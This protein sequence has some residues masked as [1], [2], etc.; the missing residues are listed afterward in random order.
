MVM[1]PRAGCWC[2]HSYNKVNGV[3]R[4]SQAPSSSLILSC[5]KWAKLASWLQVPSCANKELLTGL[6]REQWKF[7]GYVSAGHLPVASAAQFRSDPSS[8]PLSGLPVSRHECRTPPLVWWRQVVSDC[9]AIQQVH[10]T[11]HY[12]NSL[13][14]AAS[15]A[16]RAG[17]DL[18][19][20]GGR[21]HLGIG[22]C[23]LRFTYVTPVLITKLRMET[24]GQVWRLHAPSHDSGG[25]R[26]GLGGSGGR[27]RAKGE[28]KRLF[29]ESPWSQCIGACQRF[30]HPP[31][32]DK[33]TL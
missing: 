12:A 30:G 5:A 21:F 26:A 8:Y 20:C 33:Q 31:R 2:T 32:L 22:P 7:Q 27:R 13:P 3:R 23:W 15:M 11:H 17:T 10:T 4:N 18:D 24:A 14:E 19:L 25:E 16:L 9:I 29:V 6:L 28:S 1:C